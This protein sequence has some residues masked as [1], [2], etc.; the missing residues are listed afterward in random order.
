MAIN[1][2]TIEFV[3]TCD[4]CGNTAPYRN[5]METFVINE[6]KGSNKSYCSQICVEEV[7]RYTNQLTKE[8]K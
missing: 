1:P 8:G 7:I 3:F 4:R 5:G 2:R 6:E